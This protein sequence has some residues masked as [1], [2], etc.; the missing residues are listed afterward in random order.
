MKVTTTRFVPCPS[1]VLALLTLMVG[2]QSRAVAESRPNAALAREILADT[3]LAAVVEKAK[4]LLQTGFSAGGGYGEVWIRDFNTF[5]ELALTVNP[6]ATLR[7]QFLPF[8]HFQGADGN[9]PDGIISAAN[10]TYGYK[11]RT[12]ELAPHLRAHKNT[13]ETDQ[14]SSLV[15]AVGRYVRITGDTAFLDQTIADQVVR[16][17]LERALDYVRQHRFNTR[18]GLV[19]G[20]TT[21]DW[22]DVQ[23]EHV[24]GVELDENSHQAIDI[25][26]NA[27]YLTAINAFVTLPGTGAAPQRR[28]NELAMSI[29]KNVRK[30]LWDAKHSKFRP[31]LYLEKGSP[32]P[33]DF[34]EDRIHFHGGTSV[35]MEAGLLSRKE[36]VAVLGHLRANRRE[37]G[38]DSIGLTLHPCYPE[39]FFKNPQM[40]PYSYQNG[41][42]WTWFGGRTVRQL[43]RHGLVAD[44]YREVQPMVARALRD[45]FMEWYDI[46]GRPQG[47]HEYR[48][49]AGVLGEAAVLLQNW[50]RAQTGTTP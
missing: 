37:V 47:S 32:F 3:N 28:W 36:I 42:D 16:A 4:A 44:A 33:A 6:P 41:G 21:T 49:A 15:L 24:W 23:P 46:Y 14:E 39:G 10:A 30:H 17:R 48:G 34:N 20:A 11:Y 35:A 38:A 27:L 26:D 18:Y 19:W 45:G 8:F 9:I 7:A 5:I 43:I 13:V 31:H 29:R 22:G 25:Y 40:Q 50:A 2:G 1:L 12:S